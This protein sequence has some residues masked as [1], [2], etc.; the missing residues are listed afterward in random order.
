VVDGRVH[1]GV[2]D[3]LFARPLEWR[4]AVQ[5]VPIDPSAAFRKAG[6]SRFVGKYIPGMAVMPTVDCSPAHL[7]RHRRHS[8][9]IGRKA[10]SPVAGQV[11]DP[12]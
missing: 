12:W 10:S 11:R 9:R 2:G 8:E 6:S 5:V 4:L 1:K 3:W 7:R